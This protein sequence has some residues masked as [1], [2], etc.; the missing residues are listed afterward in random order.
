MLILGDARIPVAAIEKL[1]LWGSFVPFKTHNIVY[2][3]VSGHPD[4]FFC[5]VGEQWIVAPNTPGKYKNMLVQK[6]VSFREGENSVGKAYPK[7]ACYNAVATEKYI[8]HNQKVTD[9]AIKQ[10]TA[11]KTGIHV[12]QAYTRCSLLPFSRERFIT[13]DEGIYKTLLKAGMEIYY[14]SPE[15]IL[16][17]GFRNGFLG[18]CCGVFETRIFI[19]GKLSFYPEGEKMRNLLQSWNY[20]IIE[21]YDGPLFDGGGIFFIS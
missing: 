12:N 15:G 21:L 13:S 14:F 5:Q 8:I 10:Q 20:E 1:S 19:T 16:L 18:G 11:G 7:T 9:V 4:L 17:P 2:D 3:A 6:E